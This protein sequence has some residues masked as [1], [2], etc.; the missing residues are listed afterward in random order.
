ML[1]GIAAKA[2]VRALPNQLVD[3]FR[4]TIRVEDPCALPRH[5]QMTQSP[6]MVYT[7]SLQER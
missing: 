7:R 5:F 3:A 4:T 1:L 6:G 2:C